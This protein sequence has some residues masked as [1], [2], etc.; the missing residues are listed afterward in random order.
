MFQRVELL[1]ILRH[2]D[3]VLGRLFGFFVLLFND[4]LILKRLVI[5]V[6]IHRL[7]GVG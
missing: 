1:N 3:V 5:L 6:R 7:N 2:I 4:T